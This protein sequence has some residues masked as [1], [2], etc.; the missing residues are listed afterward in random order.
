MSI[1][2]FV[3]MMF[4]SSFWGAVASIYGRR[5]GTALPVAV[6]GVVSVMAS[7]APNYWILLVL[8][9]IVGIGMGG[10][11]STF[12]MYSEF[13]PVGV[14]GY[15]LCWYQLFWAVGA[16]F[17]TILAWVVLP[18]HGWRTLTLL[19]GLPAG[20]CILRVLLN[21]SF[22]CIS[23]ILFPIVLLLPESPRYLLVVGQREKAMHV[24]KKLAVING[25]SLP[26]GVLRLSRADVEPDETLH[27]RFMEQLTRSTNSCNKG[28][29][30]KC[31]MQFVCQSFQ[32]SD[33]CCLVSVLFIGSWLLR[34][35]D[36]GSICT[37][38]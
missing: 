16:V 36:T 15:N 18:R 34:C 13:L 31:F 33:S 23:V 30:M 6:E 24:L 21:L 1:V 35:C 4:G 7:I 5:Q 9:G 3:G 17:E 20:N 28:N 11:A 32:S 19:T 29:Q 14:R 26:T 27:N 38:K 8:R 12:S 25:S 22:V 37:Y 2:V 10:L